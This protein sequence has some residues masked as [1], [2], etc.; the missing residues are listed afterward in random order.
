MCQPSWH[1]LLLTLLVCPFS[2]DSLQ[3]EISGTLSLFFQGGPL[4]WDHLQ[5]HWAHFFSLFGSDRSM[6]DIISSV[7]GHFSTSSDL[8]Q[9]QKFFK[10]RDA[11][12]GNPVLQQTIETVQVSVPKFL[13]GLKS[14][15]TGQCSISEKACKVNYCLARGQ[16]QGLN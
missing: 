2:S 9:M 16:F 14:V 13:A 1:R 5:S 3:L 10:D 15:C 8:A 12:A 4:A 7:T 6:G 11:G